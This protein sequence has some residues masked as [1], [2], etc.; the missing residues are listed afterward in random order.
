MHLDWVKKPIEPNPLIRKSYF[1]FHFLPVLWERAKE[2]VRPYFQPQRSAQGIKN[3]LLGLLYFYCDVMMM[4]LLNRWK[5]MRNKSF[6]DW[7]LFVRERKQ[8]NNGVRIEAG[9]AVGCG[10]RSGTNSQDQDNPDL[11]KCQESREGY[12]EKPFL[13][14]FIALD[15]FLLCLFSSSNLLWPIWWKWCLYNNN[16]NNNT[17]MVMAMA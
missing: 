8:R 9:E 15:L 7:Y 12:P 3:S 11:K 1:E 4:M 14:L 13:F 16:N 5:T 17:N 10:W 6:F 2:A